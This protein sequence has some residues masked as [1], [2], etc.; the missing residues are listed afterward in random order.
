MAENKED[1]LWRRQQ[2]AVWNQKR[3]EQLVKERDHLVSRGQDNARRN[4]EAKEDE[5]KR[6][7]H[8]QQFLKQ[9]NWEKRGARDEDRNR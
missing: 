7:W 2:D 4:K 9:K 5:A 8:E 6:K 3:K 1:A